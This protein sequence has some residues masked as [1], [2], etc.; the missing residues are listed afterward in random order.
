MIMKIWLWVFEFRIKRVR[1]DKKI[2]FLTKQ[3]LSE[4]ELQGNAINKESE[5]FY[6]HIYKGICYIKINTNEIK[7][8]LCNK[9]VS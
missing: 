2:E 8:E 5:M 6:F 3:L 4:L 1:D 7:F 9:E